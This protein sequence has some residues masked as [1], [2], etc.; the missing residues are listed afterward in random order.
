[1]PVFGDERVDTILPNADTFLTGV[2]DPDLERLGFAKGE[3]APLGLAGEDRGN[4]DWLVPISSD[5]PS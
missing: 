1:M 5:P 3:L 4:T 2:N